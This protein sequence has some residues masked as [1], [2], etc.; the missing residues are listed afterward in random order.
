MDYDDC[1]FGDG[2]TLRADATG[3]DA[4]HAARQ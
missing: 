1:L 4:D 3:S 2:I